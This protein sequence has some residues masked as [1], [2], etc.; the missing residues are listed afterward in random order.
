MIIAWGITGA[1]HFLKESFDIFKNLKKKNKDL[2]INSFVSRA[3]E[4]VIAM[5]GLKNEL[6]GISCGDYLEEAFYESQQGS[7]FPKTGRFLL[8]RY[9]CLIVSPAT[10]NTTAKL[11][12][13]IADTLVTNAVAQ[14]VKGNVPVFIVPVDISGT[15]ESKMPYSIDREICMRCELCPPA[16]ECPEH[17]ITDQIQLL[18]CTGCGLCVRLCSFGAIRG[19]LARLK[20]RDVDSK[21]VRILQGLEGITVL[22]NPDGIPDVIKNLKSM[23]KL[24]Y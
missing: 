4:E 23:Q 12:Y 17:A 3:G 7:S 2:R 9:D 5:Y 11:A 16:E 20:V 22:D 21:N 1:G 24:K 15:I 19:G 10:S 13:G 14:A 6:S 8:K 18:K